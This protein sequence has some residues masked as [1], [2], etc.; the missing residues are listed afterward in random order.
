M[1]ARPPNDW[2]QVIYHT[3]SSTAIHTGIPATSA[4]V[5]YVE[6]PDAASAKAKVAADSSIPESWIDSVSG[7]MSPH[8]KDMAVGGNPVTGAENI[9]KSAAGKVTGWTH[10]VEQWLIRGFE[11]LLG[12]GLIIVAV[13]KLASDTPVG[14]TA[15]KAGKAAKIL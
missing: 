14:R 1:A 12:L 11:M 7:P 6:A 15:V 9:V 4:A 2:W 10:N 5:E 3:V 13:A 8:Q